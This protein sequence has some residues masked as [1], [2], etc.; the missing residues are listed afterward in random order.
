VYVADKLFATL[1]PSAR[2]LEFDNGRHAIIIDTV[3]FIRNIPTDLIAA[4]RSTLEEALSADIILNVC[5]VSD[6]EYELHCEVTLQTLADLKCNAPVI[7]VYNKCDRINQDTLYNGFLNGKLLVSA[8]R[9]DGLDNL[10][11]QIERSLFGDSL[12]VKLYIPY[13]KAK[14]IAS[15]NE[16]ATIIKSVPDDNGITFYCSISACHLE[17]FKD[18]LQINQ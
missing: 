10:R 16:K 5:D 17:E 12:N 1:D 4:F 6:R 11:K 14:E 7:T 2:K 15:V 8:A 9:G 3:G 13:A 18:F